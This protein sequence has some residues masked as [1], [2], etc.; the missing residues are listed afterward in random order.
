MPPERDPTRILP[1]PD[2]D[3]V[4]EEKERME[5]FFYIMLYAE[6]QFPLF[7]SPILCPGIKTPVPFPPPAGRGKGVRAIAIER[8]IM[9]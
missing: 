7:S 4:F 6:T 1:Y 2:D 5:T 8:K 9:I 3:T